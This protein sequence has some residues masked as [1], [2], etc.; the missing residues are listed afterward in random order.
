M[1]E[2]RA[3]GHFD[4]AWIHMDETDDPEFFIR[5][6]DASRVR[7]LEFARK[8]PEIA[9]AHLELKPGL[10]VLD[11]GC[12]TGDMLAVIAPL[13]A[14]G[15]A[16]GGDLSATMLQVARQRAA[17]TGI[18]NLRFEHMDIQSLAYGDESF[19]RVLATQLLIHVPDPRSA[20]HEICRVTKR[21]GIVAIADVDWDT[22]VIGCT[23]K[24]LA[25]RCT[26]LFSDG[27]RNGLVVREYAG[28]LRSEGFTN[29][30]MIPQQV[31]FDDWTGV[32]EWILEPALPHFI[33]KGVMS[34]AE[35]KSIVD[36]LADRNAND[37][38][39]AAMTIYTVTGQRP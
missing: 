20:L 14:P 18:A 38:F 30:K 1:I 5:F 13:I 37:H 17:A 9:F 36:D 34:E 35:A 25:R 12:G 4:D 8:N 27:I 2:K 23:N 33:A 28:W 15:E 21:N 16:C 10:S 31:V 6:L 26:H 7:A 29:I 39:L 19:D 32:K 3:T 11:C 24:D 22:L